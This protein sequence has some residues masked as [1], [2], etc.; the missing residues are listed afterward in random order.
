[1]I[2]PVFPSDRAGCILFMSN[3]RRERKQVLPQKIIYTDNF[4]LN[5]FL[6]RILP[7]FSPLSTQCKKGADCNQSKKIC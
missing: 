7:P 1:M 3:I 4:R 5:I 2:T 6:F